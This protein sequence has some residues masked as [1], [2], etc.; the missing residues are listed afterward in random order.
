MTQLCSNYT[1]LPSM[2]NCS[3]SNP[4]NVTNITNQ[5][6]LSTGAVAGIAIGLFILGVIVGII[7]QLIVAFLIRWC[8]NKGG[9]INFGKSVKYEKHEENISL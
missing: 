9:S 6:G 3:S 4:Q 2:C 1:G 8:R 7:L 5:L